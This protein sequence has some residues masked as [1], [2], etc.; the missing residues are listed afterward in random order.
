MKSTDENGQTKA[1][2]GQKWVCMYIE[3]MST[4]KWAVLLKLSMVN[5]LKKKK[6]YPGLLVQ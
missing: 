6:V 3:Q 1:P 4:R 2:E 5:H